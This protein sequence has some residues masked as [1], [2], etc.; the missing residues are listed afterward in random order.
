M[1]TLKLAHLFTLDVQSYGTTVRLPWIGEAFIRWRRDAVG[2]RV[3]W[4][5]WSELAF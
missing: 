2:R 5:P 1:L 3:T 4:S